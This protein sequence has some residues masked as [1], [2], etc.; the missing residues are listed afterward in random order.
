MRTVGGC[1]LYGRTHNLP[2]ARRGPGYGITLSGA[3]AE[4]FPL[5]CVRFDG[6]GA[7]H[8]TKKAPATKPASTSS[9]SKT[10][11]SKAPTISPNPT[12]SPRKSSKTLKPSSSRAWAVVW[13]L[14]SD[15][16]ILTI[17]G[18]LTG[19]D[20]FSTHAEAPAPPAD[21]SD[22]DTCHVCSIAKTW[23]HAA[24]LSEASLTPRSRQCQNVH[25]RLSGG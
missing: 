13:R 19:R 20:F 14:E 17:S 23:R 8:A 18:I 1:D 12:F 15:L 22:P 2:V 9:G 6:C 21:L 11:A 24:E 16:A 3:F 5:S 10:K 4:P 7:H 25:R